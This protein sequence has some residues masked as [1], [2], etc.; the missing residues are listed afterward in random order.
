MQLAESPTAARRGRARRRARPCSRR[1]AAPACRRPAVAAALRLRRRRGRGCGGGRGRRRPAGARHARDRQ[2]AARERHHGLGGDPDRRLAARARVADLARRRGQGAQVAH[3]VARAVAAHL[4]RVAARGHEPLDRPGGR[5]RVRRPAGDQREAAVGRL[6]AHHPARRALHHAR[7]LAARGGERLQRRA[8][9]VDAGRPA[10]TAE[11]EAAVAVGLPGDPARRPAHAAVPRRAARGAQREHGERGR[12][13]AAGEG[14]VAALLGVQ[15]AHEVAVA[16][17]RRQPRGAQHQDRAVDLAEVAQVGQ[18]VGVRPDVLGGARRAGVARVGPGRRQ[19]ER[20]PARVELRRRLAGRGTPAAVVV[21]GLQQPALGGARRGRVR[22]PRLGGRGRAGEQHERDE[23]RRRGRHPVHV[24]ARAVAVERADQHRAEREAERGAAE[25]VGDVERERGGHDRPQLGEMVVRVGDP[26]M[27]V[28]HEPEPE[29][30][31]DAGGGQAPAAELAAE[32]AR[33]Q[34]AADPDPAPRDHLPRR[35]RAL[36]EEQVRRQRRHRPDREPGRAAEHVAGDQDDVG[37]RL[38]VRQ[39][40]ERDPAERGQRRQR[41]DER[42][43]LRGR[44]RPLVPGEAREQRQAEDREARADPDHRSTSG[45]AAASSAA[46]DCGSSAPPAPPSTA[47]GLGGEVPA[48]AEHLGGRR[49]GDRAA[50]AEQD[51]ARRPR[52]RELGVVR[53]DEHGGAVRGQLAQARR[54]RGAVRPV[55]AARR[56]VEA[57]RDR[58]L[59]AAQHELER[60][61]LALAAGDVARVAVGQRAG[62]RHVVADALVQ[63]Q[64]ARVLQQQRDAPGPAHLAARRVDQPGEQAQQRRLAGAVA[65]HQRDRLAGCELEVDALQD[66]RPVGDLVPRAA[67][68]DDGVTVAAA[69]RGRLGR[70]RQPGQAVGQRAARALHGRRPLGHA[71]ER[72][73]ARD[74]RLQLGRRPGG[75]RLRVAVERDAAVAQRDDAVGRGQAALEPVLG[76][77]HR[78]PPLLVDPPQHAEQLVARD[79]VE[80]RG[81]LVEQQQPRAAG[82]RGAER[83]PLQLAAGQLARRALQQRRDAER[84][85]G[86]LDAARHRRAAPAAVLERE[87]QLGADGAHDHLGLGILEQRAGDRGERGRAVLARVQPAAGELARERAAVEVRHEPGGRAQERRLARA[88]GAGQHDELARLDRQRHVAQRRLGAGVGVGHAG[89]LEH[90]HRPIP[91]RSANGSSAQAASAAASTS[92]RASNGTTVSG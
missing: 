42:E 67:R 47:R 81:R 15:L 52:G 7:A 44:P 18:L 66:R 23:A 27:Q 79:R 68:G 46:P 21:L 33:Q 5:L 86:L 69:R 82:E 60:E 48:T 36:G 50:G 58:R 20:G 24:E 31:G 61:P 57:D 73:Q 32:H 8:G 83:H 71:G 17:P 70:G 63:E 13:D 26:E 9:V 22:V 6:V 92:R 53:R 19:A 34:R 90:A 54:E 12:V 62:A 55:H 51:R 4:R 35:P 3:R 37:R 72:A 38:H 11:V 77:Q 40:R 56:L 85:R 1:T 16:E 29:R 84:Q 30:G 25:R 28:H 76:Q 91:R 10:A 39:R 59:A 45:R 64:V 14:A 75:E 2:R 87:R 88:G 89:Q 78:R 41:G 49:V 43:H 80:L 65:A 74:R